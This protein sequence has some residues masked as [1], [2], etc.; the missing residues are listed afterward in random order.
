MEDKFIS[1]LCKKYDEKYTR[2][3][4]FFL[5]ILGI[6]LASALIIGYYQIG[7][8]GT[9]KRQQDINTANIQ[10]LMDNSVSQKAIDMLCISFENQTRVMEQF[11]PNNISQA[12]KEFNKTSA[13][14]RSYITRYNTDL[15][16]RGGSEPN[17][18]AK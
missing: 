6:F 9:V 4:G 16:S 8:A 2:M 5:S 13:N 11:F 18:G 7:S 3:Q 17:G 10:Y 12:V 1:E 15:N 14:L